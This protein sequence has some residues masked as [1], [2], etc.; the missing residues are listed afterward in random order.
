MPKFTKVTCHHC[1]KEFT[2][3]AGK[4]NEAVRNNWNQFCSSECQRLNKTTSVYCSCIRC[5]TQVLRS[6]S[7][8][9]DSVFCSHSCS[10]IYN[11]TLMPKR[12]KTKLCA[13][14]KTPI[15]SSRVYCPECIR[16]CK[17]QH[18]TGR[19]LSA[20]MRENPISR[21]K[22]SLGNYKSEYK[23]SICSR[24]MLI[25]NFTM[26]RNGKV[27]PWCKQ[28]NTIIVKKKRS[29]LK[30]QCFDYLKTSSCALCGYN[31]NISALDFHHTDP[32]IKE[33]SFSKYKKTVLG[34]ALKSE[35]DKCI[36]VCSN[37]HRELHNPTNAQ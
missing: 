30:L 29:K 3:P 32:S 11:N 15:V 9:G 12:I 16:S 10:A 34:D 35:L 17:A 27:H 13:I 36:V 2:R 24:I 4:Y 22:D 19:K 6:P 21:L 1:G 8:I 7:N 37:C 28:C 31:K 14:C 33:F 26:L 5:G 18:A 23:C 25:D 20:T